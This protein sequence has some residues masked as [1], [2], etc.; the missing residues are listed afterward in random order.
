MTKQ[1]IVWKKISEEEPNLGEEVLVKDCIDDL[2]IAKKVGECEYHC[3]ADG[4][5]VE[6]YGFNYTEVRTVEPVLWARIL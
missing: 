3:M 1:T 5:V 4:S 6:D 2:S